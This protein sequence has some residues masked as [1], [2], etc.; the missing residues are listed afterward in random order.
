[1]KTAVSTTTDPTTTQLLW[2]SCFFSASNASLSAASRASRSCSSTIAT[3]LLCSS[4]GNLSFFNVLPSN[5]TMSSMYRYLLLKQLSTTSSENQCSR[6]KMLT[7]VRSLW[8]SVSL[9]L[10]SSFS[11]LL[12]ALSC[13][14]WASLAFRASSMSAGVCPALLLCCSSRPNFT[15][16]SYSGLELICLAMWSPVFPSGS[17]ANLSTRSQ[18]PRSMTLWLNL[19]SQAKINGDLP[20]PLLAFTS[21]ACSPRRN[22]TNSW[23]SP[24]IA[25]CSGRS[26]ASS[27]VHKFGSALPLQ[28]VAHRSCEAIS[29]AM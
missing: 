28:R 1:M 11:F 5:F 8:S 2:L 21:T 23:C 22:S 3:S 15:K 19:P 18:A 17:V 13:S 10:R 12:S 29:A 14:A 26:P 7:S 20:F 4:A 6:R 27:A 16:R 9:R 25:T 24:L